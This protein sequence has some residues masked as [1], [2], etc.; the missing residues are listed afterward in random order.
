MHHQK[1]KAPLLDL[2][3]V[4]TSFQGKSPKRLFDIPEAPTFHPTAKE[5]IDPMKYIQSIKDIGEKT[6]IVKIVPPE[7]WN[8]TFA[9]DTEV[10]R[11]SNKELLVQDQDTA[12]E[13]NGWKQSQLA[14]LLREVAEIPLPERRRVYSAVYQQTASGPA[15]AEKTSEVTTPKKEMSMKRM[16][17]SPSKVEVVKKTEFPKGNEVQIVLQKVC[18]KCSKTKT[19]GTI[20]ICD[21]CESAYHL[22]CLTQP[23]LEVPETTWL[24][25]KCIVEHGNDYGFVDKPELRSLAEFQKYSDNFKDRWFKQ[26]YEIPG[27]RVSEEL[28]EKEFWRLISSPYEEVSVEYGAD[29]HSSELGSGFPNIERHPLDKYS[30]CAWNLNNLAILPGSLF[31]NIP[32]DISGM[33]IPWVYVGMVFS[34]FCWH[35]E[36][37]YTYSINYN[38]IGETKTWYGI[39]ASSADKFEETMKAKVP[40]LFESNPDL[41]FHLTTLLSPEVLVEN[42]V[43]VFTINQRP[44]DFVVTFPRAYH[45]GFNHGFN[46]C[47]AVNFAPLDWLPFGR[48]CVKLYSQFGKQP[49]FSHEELVLT[50]AQSKL[51]DK[52]ALSILPELEV[53]IKEEK[54]VRNHVLNELKIEKKLVPPIVFAEDKDQCLECKAFCFLSAI[55]CPNHPNVVLCSKHAFAK[56]CSCRETERI[57]QIRYTEEMLE[58]IYKDVSHHSEIPR[59]WKQ[60]VI[61][62]YD[63]NPRPPLKDLLKLAKEGEK[64]TSSFEAVHDFNVFVKACQKL[65]DDASKILQRSKRNSKFADS[66][67]TME[68]LEIMIDKFNTLPFDAPE[69]KSVE[70]LLGQAKKVEEE[71]LELLAK[72]VKN[73]KELKEF[74][75]AGLLLN[76]DIPALKQIDIEN[77]KQDWLRNYANLTDLQHVELEDVQRVLSVAKELNIQHTIVQ[78]MEKLVDEGEAWLAEANKLLKSSSASIQQIN[79]MIEKSTLCPAV[80]KI[81]Q[82]L[83]FQ[84]TQADKIIEH[85]KTFA[86]RP[87]IF[88]LSQLAELEADDLDEID[89]LIEQAQVINTVIPGVNDLKYALNLADTWLI[90]VQKLLKLPDEESLEDWL[91]EFNYSLKKVVNDESA[92]CI[93]VAHSGK[94]FLVK[95]SECQQFY[96]GSCLGLTKKDATDDFVCPCC[97]IEVGYNPEKKVHLEKLVKLANEVIHHHFHSK[98]SIELAKGVVELLEWESSIQRY[99]N[100]S[101]SV[102]NLRNL[103]RRIYRLNVQ[104]PVTRKLENAIIS[105]TKPVCTCQTVY[106]EKKPMIECEKCNKWYHK[107]CV[108]Y[109]GLDFICDL[110]AP[111]P[112][113]KR[114][115]LEEKVSE[116]H[117]ETTQSIRKDIPTITKANLSNSTLVD[118]INPTK[119]LGTQPY[120]PNYRSVASNDQEAGNFKNL[121][122]DEPVELKT[123]YVNSRPEQNIRKRTFVEQESPEKSRKLVKRTDYS[124]SSIDEHGRDADYYRRPY[125]RT[126][127]SHHQ[128]SP[129][130]YY[131]RYPRKDSL[132]GSERERPIEI[133]DV[134]SNSEQVSASQLYRGDYPAIIPVPNYPP[135]NV[136]PA[137]PP[138][139][140][141]SYYPSPYYNYDPHAHHGHP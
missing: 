95:C 67:H 22:T 39:P 20:I 93:C 96:H 90:K 126:Q 26:K 119:F 58:N 13:F 88:T 51:D 111:T 66:V 30:K 72:D 17:Q 10:S 137:Y 113:S 131:H 115:K 24:C 120:K 128:L 8:P 130:V 79:D 114:L 121:E 129:A 31:G 102:E 1:G 98:H 124:D 106:D 136:Y 44:G 41:L 65:C 105:F 59:Q 100:N 110:C 125:E 94:G 112:R 71:A 64:I 140:V 43:K 28:C 42:K 77:R 69:S 36:D 45:A 117:K 68:D 118:E 86:Q 32:N 37:H 132:P 141:H 48:E 89:D 56:V 5:F 34:A 38:H 40:E 23:L 107:S 108:L 60:K 87:K 61:D 35:F 46:I 123:W 2:R 134:E 9:I 3:S 4:R 33:M 73:A 47:E 127:V 62:L 75:E 70:Q 15:S 82:K 101:P 27:H 80:T 18:V 104:L 97:D 109:D 103:L 135:P 133:S 6:G 14:T 50:T 81:V 29:I 92:N 57:F 52:I 11:R 76:I 78:D 12:F 53:M 54:E 49:V 7:G 83:T 85:A 84:I 19:S 116:V 122:K 25:K 91:K 74:Y 99:I 21:E 55:T 16:K 63:E 139:Y 138:Y